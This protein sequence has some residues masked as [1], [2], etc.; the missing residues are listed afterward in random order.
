MGSTSAYE[1]TEEEL[2][3]ARSVEYPVKLMY[4][5]E[6]ACDLGATLQV[7]EGVFVVSHRNFID[8]HTVAHSYEG[9]YS[10][11]NLCELE[12]A[13]NAEEDDQ[14]KDRAREAARVVALSK[15]TPAE[16]KLLGL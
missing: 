1:R 15:L 11:N 16:R 9:S 13:V 4:L 3:P 6:R 5:L 8:A 7:V 10:W 2:A 12:D 14:E